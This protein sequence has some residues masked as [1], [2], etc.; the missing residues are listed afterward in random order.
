MEKFNCQCATVS[1]IV[2]I[3]DDC[4]LNADTSRNQLTSTIQA[5]MLTNRKKHIVDLQVFLVHLPFRIV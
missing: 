4:L 2:V 5:V 3:I 1:I